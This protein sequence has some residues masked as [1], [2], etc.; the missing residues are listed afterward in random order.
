MKHDLAP[1]SV[2]VLPT[3]ADQL[4]H[5]VSEVLNPLYVA[6]P[7]FLVVALHSSSS[8]TRGLLW[9]LVTTVCVSVVPLM[10]VARGVQRGHLTDKHVSVRE[11]RLIPMVVGIA[12]IGIAFG[13]LIA[14]QASRAFLAA[15]VGALLAG[16]LALAITTR[17]K[18]SLH[19]VGT[20]GAVTV[21]VL[22]FGSPMLILAPL[23]PLVAWA[24]WQ[25][26]AHSWLQA[27]AGTVLGVGVTLGVFW[28][29]HVK[30]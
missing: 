27:I 19:L 18:I 8:I 30:G 21:F 29:F 5:V 9:W 20:A 28:A 2:P 6:I 1:P 17:W 7:T 10:Y 23:V 13:V 12:S 3:R 25:V 26:R 4:G 15:V 24:R 11:Q 14:L 22:L 16:V